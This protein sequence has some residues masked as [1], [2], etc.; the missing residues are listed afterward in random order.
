MIF[1]AKPEFSDLTTDGDTIQLSERFSL[2][3]DIRPDE[4]TSIED[5]DCFGKIEESR[6]TNDYGWPV[7]PDGF[8]GAARIVDRDRFSVTWW[9]PWEGAS[10]E[11]AK[12]FLPTLS[13]LRNYGWDLIGLTLVEHVSDSC[14]GT[15][16]VDVTTAWLGGVEAMC[17]DSYRSEVASD[18]WHEIRHEMVAKVPA[19]A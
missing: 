2:R 14:G 5:Y 9:Q 6:R 1:L 8:D 12:K 18:L 19:H 11:D 15:H 13:D 7:R 16:E 17:E 10:E 4:D 3:L